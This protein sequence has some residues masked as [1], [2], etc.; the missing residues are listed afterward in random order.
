MYQILITVSK[1]IIEEVVFFHDPK[2]AIEALSRYVKDMN[3]EH[4]DA[5]LY[6]PDGLIANAKNF[7]DNKD[8]YIENRALIEEINDK[9]NKPIYIIGNP[10]HYLGFMVVSTD[11]PMGY[12][13]PAEALTELGR[14]RKDWGKHLRLYRVL[15]VKTPIVSRNHLKRYHTDCEVEDFDYSVVEEYIDRKA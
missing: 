4:N 5:A 2:R 11:D 14:M 6:G 1:G 8:E 13:D 10:D 3:P 7:L 12:N 15:P 9:G